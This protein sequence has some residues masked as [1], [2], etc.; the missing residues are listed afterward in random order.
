LK[1]TYYGQRGME[2]RSATV[3]IMATSRVAAKRVLAVEKWLI[4][5]SHPASPL[6]ISR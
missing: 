2:I 4:V 3:S 6:Y 5:L 1:W